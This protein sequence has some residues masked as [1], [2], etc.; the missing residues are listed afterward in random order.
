MIKCLQENFSSDI[1]LFLELSFRERNPIDRKTFEYI[2]KSA[3]YW[4]RS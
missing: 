4:L 2:S 3:D 1:D